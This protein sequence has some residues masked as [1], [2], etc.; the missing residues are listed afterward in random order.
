MTALIDQKL[1]DCFQ[2]ERIQDAFK[3]YEAAKQDFFD[4]LKINIR[5]GADGISYST[6]SDELEL[7][8][9]LISNRVLK[10]TYQFYPFREVRRLKSPGKERVLSIATIR[11]V[12]VQK[13]LY[14]VIYDD[15]EAK[16][17]ETQTLNLASWAYRK[18]KS[19]PSAIK[20]IHSYINQGYQ[21]AFDAD[22][23]EFFDRIPH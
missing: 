10:G 21:F 1:Y 12:I 14:E 3:Q 18:H 15:I 19:A 8:C 23:V 16:F 11:D 2:P 6:F 9:Q 4:E 7:R 22:I 20:L 5:M 13:L 17:K